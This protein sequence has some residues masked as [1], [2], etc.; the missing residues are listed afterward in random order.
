MRKILFLP[1][2]AIFFC[3]GC[4]SYYYGDD[5]DLDYHDFIKEEYE[6][7]FISSIPEKYTID[8]IYDSEDIIEFAH[9]YYYPEDIYDIDELIESLERQ[10]YTI[11]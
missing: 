1:I 7:D 2:C 11:E 5:P 3:S 9:D 6:A 10:G 4:S 8:E